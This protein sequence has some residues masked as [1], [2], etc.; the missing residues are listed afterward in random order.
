[1]K[2]TISERRK[3]VRTDWA[4]QV[5]IDLLHPPI[6][7]SPTNINFG[8]GG[9]CLRMEKALEVR[10][11]VRMRL[12][13][14]VS[15]P[16]PGRQEVECTGRVAWVMQR[17]DLRGM[18]PFVFDVGI[19]F[20]EPSS[21]LRQLLSRVSGLAVRAAQTRT[22][23]PVASA[24]IRDRR[25][26]AYLERD[27]VRPSAWHLI[28]SVDGVPCFSSRYPTERSALDAWTQFKRR[29]SRTREVR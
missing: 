23:P 9:V 26:T 18:P 27:G 29:Q 6:A 15:G 22:R 17:M 21:A 5:A 25:Y 7:S 11:L 13:P 12:R 19:E 2:S 28:V 1:M 4:G 14:E 8:E 16:R 24:V 20:V 3:F 10:T